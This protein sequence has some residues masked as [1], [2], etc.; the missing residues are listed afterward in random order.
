[1]SRIRTIKPEFWKNE[2]LSELPEAAHMLAAALLNYADDEGYFN[3]NPKLI[4]GE[5]FPLREL[6]VSIPDG[7]T[8]LAD[9]GYLRLGKGADGK[10]YGHIVHFSDHQKINRPTASKIKAMQVSW[11]DAG[12]T[13]AQLTES[14]LLEGNREGNR[15]QGNARGASRKIIDEAFKAFSAA[16]PKRKGNDPSQPAREKFERAVRDGADPDAIIRG[17]QGYAVEQSKIGKVGT[18]F[19]K[20]RKAWLNEKGWQDYQGPT[21]NGHPIIAPPQVWLTEDDP[22]WPKAAELWREAKGKP[23]PILAGAHGNAGRGWHF[24][25]T[26]VRS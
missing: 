14:S 16:Y 13:H 22:R 5:C 17:A 4:Q 10:R 6:S 20:Q 12:I 18:E 7:L 9:D 19:I 3:A 15:E 21:M 8:Q 24:P 2:R 1:M 23:P 25:E 26:M 11:E